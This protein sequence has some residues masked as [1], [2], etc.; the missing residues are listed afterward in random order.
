MANNTNKN[1][2]TKKLSSIAATA[3]IVNQVVVEKQALP[4]AIQKYTSTIKESELA[5]VQAY[6]YNVLRRYEFYQEICNNLLSKKL[7]NKDQ[8]IYHLIICGLMLINEANLPAHAAINETVNVTKKSKKSWSKNLVNA[9][10]RRYQRE[11]D[12]LN[13]AA[14]KPDCSHYCCPDWLL[15]K[16]QS[17]YPK[18]DMN[19]TSNW[20]EILEANLC[21]PPMTLRVNQQQHSREEYLKLLS[22]AD[23]A[24]THCTLTQHGITLK[25][26]VNIEQLPLFNEGAV[27]VQDS[28]AQLSAEILQAHSN[29]K[30]LDAC[31]APGGKT[32]HIIESTPD[33]RQLIAID[34]SAKRLKRVE[35]NVNRLAA[36]QA[37]KIQLISADAAD[38]DSWWDKEPFDKILLDA[39]CSATGVIR[40]HPDIKR[41]RQPSDIDSLL[42]TQQHLLEKLWLILKEGGILLY[43]TCSILPEENSQQIKHFLSTHND[44]KS[45]D[46]DV[47]WGIKSEFGRQLLPTNSETINNNG[48]NSDGF[49]YCLLQKNT[50]T[51]KR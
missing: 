37:T 34:V 39:P 2:A 5:R 10:L 38:T 25:Q 44:A 48:Q 20:Q 47:S 29:E 3:S 51:N 49:Y 14:L 26:A 36:K 1:Q 11:Q 16:I 15:T 40:R 30:I 7:K 42:I 18:T 21:H 45:I 8:D 35:E 43:A 9:L 6:C 31:A 32:L 4:D 12:S 22:D 24:A 13:Q 50:N 17:S 46:F 27:S 33:I 41:L 28:A 19:N 23:I